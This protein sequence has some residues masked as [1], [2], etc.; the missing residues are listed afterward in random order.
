MQPGI[1]QHGADINEDV[2]DEWQ[3]PAPSQIKEEA[4]EEFLHFK[5]EEKQQPSYLKK[6]K[7]PESPCR[8]EVRLEL[9]DIKVEEEDRWNASRVVEPPSSSSW[10]HITTKGDGGCQADGLL[11]PLSDCDGVLSHAHHTDDDEQSEGDLA[12]HT[13]NKC[14][15]CFQCGNAFSFKSRLKQHV[16][17]HTG[18]KPFACSDC[19]QRFSKKGS[20]TRHTRTHN[21]EK[22]FAC[23]VCSQ[24]FSHNRNLKIHTRIH[25]VEKPF[26]C[27][28]CGQS[29]SQ[30]TNVKIHTRTH[31]GEKHF[32]CLVCGQ[33]F[34]L[35]TSLKIH[36]RTH[37]GEKPFACSVCGQRFS[38]KSFV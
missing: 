31:T 32:A 15:K 4:C 34:S 30:K 23:S 13:D 19:A 5:E 35:K 16:R 12:G 9:P 10:E 20:L 29:F 22:P 3:E 8:K 36:T 26:S 28:V 11:A 7:E 33:R 27:S 14:W 6:E 2:Q 25:T 21:S 18:E 38:R 24:R 37:T 17:I 1:V